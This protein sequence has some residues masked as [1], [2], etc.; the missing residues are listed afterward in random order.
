MTD[1]EILEAYKQQMITA[2]IE[3]FNAAYNALKHKGNWVVKG[4]G[5]THYYVCDRCGCDGDIQDD[6]CRHCGADMR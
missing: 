6:F 1:T 4:S 3:A 2:S 5:S